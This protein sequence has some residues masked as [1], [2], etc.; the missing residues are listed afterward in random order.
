[1]KVIVFYK[2]ESEHATQV[3]EYLRDF[4]RQTGKELETMNPDSAE[5]AQLCRVYDI[6]EYPSMIA[7]S[8]DGLLQTSWRGLP[9]PLISEVSYYS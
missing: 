9:L 1:M 4:S 2:P 3:E 6:V 7:L 8:D 5:G